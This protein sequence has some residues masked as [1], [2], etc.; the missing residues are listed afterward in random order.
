LNV[1]AGS[2]PETFAEEIV[3][4]VARRVFA[5]S[6]FGYGQEPE[7][8]AAETPTFVARVSQ[9]GRVFV[10]PVPPHDAMSNPEAT[11]GTTPRRRRP[12]VVTSVT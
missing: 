8:F 9:M 5:R 11:I 7:L 4:S 2:S 10:L 12:L 1:H 3:E 6:A